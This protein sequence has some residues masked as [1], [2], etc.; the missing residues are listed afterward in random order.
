MITSAA[1]LRSAEDIAPVLVQAFA[2]AARARPA[3]GSGS[4]TYSPYS[5]LAP[6][7]GWSRLGAPGMAPT[8]EHDV[9]T[10]ALAAGLSLILL[11]LG[12]VLKK[13]LGR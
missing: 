9:S 13:R 5:E 3:H 6:W 12:D 4:H 1:M 11:G 7:P 8:S 10:L 2:C